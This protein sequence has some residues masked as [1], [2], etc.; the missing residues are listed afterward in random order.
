M[1]NLIFDPVLIFLKFFV[2]L[3]SLWNGGQFLGLRHKLTRFLV[4]HGLRPPR[5]E[6]YACQSTKTMHCLIEHHFANTKI[7][8]TSAQW[9]RSPS[10]LRQNISDK[11][12]MFRVIEE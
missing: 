3:A 8:K 11:F 2:S 5:R 7:K 4:N 10:V 6:F 12:P 1:F 9:K